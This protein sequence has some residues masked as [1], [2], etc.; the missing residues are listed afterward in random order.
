MRST[1]LGLLVLVGCSP[2]GVGPVTTAGVAP[3][4]IVAAPVTVTPTPTP[5]PTERA[6]VTEEAR[7]HARVAFAQALEL[8]SNGRAREATAMVALGLSTL[9]RHLPE[10]GTVEQLGSLMESAVFSADASMYSLGDAET[11]LVADA[12]SG[13]LIGLRLHD[14]ENALIGPS[15]SPSAS[16]VVAPSGPDLLVYESRGLTLRRR[17]SARN[18]APFTFLSDDKLVTV[19]LGSSETAMPVSRTQLI[20]RSLPA[21][22]GQGGVDSPE[23]ASED[24]GELADDEIVLIDLATGKLDR[25]FKLS[26]PP[27]LG[28]MRKV[29]SLPPSQHCNDVD[30]CRRYELNPIPIGRRVEQLKISAGMIVASWRGGA[31]TFHRLKDGKL[32]GAFRS[33]GERWKP[34]LVA[35]WPKPPRAAVVTSLPNV[36]RGSEPPFSVT[37]LIDLNRGRVLELIDEC[38]WATG[39]AFSQDGT[40][41]MVGDLRRACLHDGRTGRHLDTTD[42]VRPARG[43]DDDL[44]DV[45]VRSIPGDRWLLRTADGAFGVFDEKGGKTLLRGK[46]DGAESLVASD[47]KSLFVAD[48]SGGEAQLITF[49][50][51][52]IERRM[53]RTEELEQK[54]FPPEVA[55]SPEGRRAA[56]LAR[57][58]ANSCLIEGFRLPKE[59]CGAVSTVP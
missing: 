24:G 31:T 53:L 58:V 32:L 56:A 7:V 59:L 54:V 17:V 38:R 33:R 43:Y 30:E 19:R 34:G 11:V 15:I 35:I 36:G 29:A 20:T 10:D 5:A 4:P 26:P 18:D 25:T 6:A 27:D 21:R 16:V 1:L 14:S 42:E 52:G 22:S 23:Q 50:S 49:N 39:L 51:S 55:N 13:R 40:K 48:F 2:L 9:G 57:M 47:D 3:I 28:L 41:L 46:G 44:Q 8:W 12:A 37:A 45:S